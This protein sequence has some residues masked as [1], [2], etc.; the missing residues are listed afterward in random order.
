[1]VGKT[2]KKPLIGICIEW[3][4]GKIPPRDSWSFLQI[5]RYLPA[6]FYL[7]S[8]K[9]INWKIYEIQGYALAAKASNRVH[10]QSFPLPQAVYNRIP[11]RHSEATRAFQ[12]MRSK[13]P[14][15]GIKMFNPRFFNKPEIHRHLNSTSLIRNHLPKTYLGL[16][17]HNLVQT[18]GQFPA[19]FIKQ[20]NGSLGIGVVKVEKTSSGYIIC[21]RYKQT[22]LR[23]SVSNIQRLYSRLLPLVGRGA[24]VQQAIPLA[25]YKGKVFDLR[26]L[27]QRDGNNQWYRTYSFAKVA[28]QGSVASNIAAG[29]TVASS[30]RVLTQAFPNLDTRRSIDKQ[31]TRLCSLIPRI[32]SKHYSYLGELGID[33]GVDRRGKV[34]IIEVNSKYSRHVFPKAI[35]RL[36][37]KRPLRYALRLAKG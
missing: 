17:I 24:I 18:L 35:R 31:I 25:H 34:W 36:S 9:D 12:L 14:R 5:G 13:F 37:I 3:S 20:R 7:F 6:K 27:L 8:P 19:V 1:M 30:S 22:N 10:R 15:L 2:S 23:I 26:V 11:L 29:G 32:L 16:S 28:P 4:K 21:Y 33:F